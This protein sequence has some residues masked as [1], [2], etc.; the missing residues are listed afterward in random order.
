MD[1]VGVPTPPMGGVCNVQ[2]TSQP[3]TIN[4]DIKYHYRIR[5]ST[6]SLQFLTP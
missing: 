4:P 3:F 5:I 1:Y 2:Y 6:Q